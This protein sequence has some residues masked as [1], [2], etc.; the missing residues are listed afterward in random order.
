MGSKTKLL[1]IPFE[2]DTLL[3]GLV[4]DVESIIELVE[5]LQTTHTNVEVSPPSAESEAIH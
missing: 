4:S 5:F 1:E 3:E 2:I